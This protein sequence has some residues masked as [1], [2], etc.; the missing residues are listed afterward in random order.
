MKAGLIAVLFAVLLTGVAPASAE[1]PTREE[2]VAEVARTT[3]LASDAVSLALDANPQW[4]DRLGTAVSTVVV[5]D[6]LLSARDT[7]L[8]VDLLSDQAVNQALSVLPGAV[9]GFVKAVGVYKSALEFIRDHAFV[10]AMEARVY[11]EYKRARGGRMDYSYAGPAEA[12]DQAI[13]N[14]FGASGGVNFKGYWPQ[15]K[16]QFDRLVKSQGYNPD[17]VGDKLAAALKRK[18]DDFWTK[19]L[20]VAY[21]AELLGKDRKSLTDQVWDT[22]AD[23]IDQLYLPV[24]AGID[25]GLFLDPGGDLPDGWWH[26]TRG[27]DATGHERPEPTETGMPTAFAAWQ[28][29]TVSD[30]DPAKH[31]YFY[32]ESA[33]NWCRKEGTRRSCD[34][35]RL[36]VYLI[37]WQYPDA[38]MAR[39]SNDAMLAQPG[40]RSLGTGIGWKPFPDQSRIILDFVVGPYT[41]HFVFDGIGQHGQPALEEAE[42]FARIVAKRIQ[43]RVQ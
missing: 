14:A 27:D 29:F 1:T 36:S 17:L 24:A 34:L 25:P 18:L 42:Y 28:Q 21:E 11:A 6:K 8:V 10:P 2:I 20:E 22:V 40:Y 30:T 39:A 4:L 41:A 38:D 3:G 35:S 13:F 19:R 23:I 5:I 16:A 31:G 9:S 43:A 37:I 32:V 26:I 12:F 33:R 15:Y 7:E